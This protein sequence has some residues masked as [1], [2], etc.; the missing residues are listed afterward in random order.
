MKVGDYVTI[1]KLVEK[2]STMSQLVF[3]LP[4]FYDSDKKIA[5]SFLKFIN[6]HPDIR[7]VSANLAGDRAKAKWLKDAMHKL[8]DN[9]SSNDPNGKPV[10]DKIKEFIFDSSK[11][12]PTSRYEF[13]DIEKCEEF[14]NFDKTSILSLNDSQ[15]NLC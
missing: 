2:D 9:N 6:K 3:R 11:A 12:T 15:K 1:G 13:Y 7:E 8:S 14:I 5:A 4:C 10:N